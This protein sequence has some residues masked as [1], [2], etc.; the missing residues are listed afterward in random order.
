MENKSFLLTRTYEAPLE[1]VWKAITEKEQLKHWYFDFSE[2]FKLELGSTFFWSG[3]DHDGTKFMHK[4]EMLEMLENKKLVHS[5]EYPDYSG[6][7]VVTWELSKVDENT[8]QLDFKHEFI[9]PFDA[10][11]PSLRRESFVE[12]WTHILTISLV[13]YLKN[14]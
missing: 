6:T 7:S 12:G 13:E 5:W 8:T 14:T 1:L 9:V 2:G 4:G 3:C 11:V 10:S